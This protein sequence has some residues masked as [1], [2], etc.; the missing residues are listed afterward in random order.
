MVWLQFQLFP[1]VPFVAMH[2]NTASWIL[3]IRYDCSLKTQSALGKF[4]RLSLRNH[5][6]KS[7]QEV[8]VIREV[9][10]TF[11]CSRLHT[12]RFPTDLQAIIT[13]QRVLKKKKSPN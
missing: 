3:F 13:H 11:F 5:G 9:S 8:E 10:M 6:F 2:V 1:E 4:T 12:P 7:K